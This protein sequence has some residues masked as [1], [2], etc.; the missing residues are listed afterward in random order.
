MKTVKLN[1]KE[2]KTDQIRIKENKA[3]KKTNDTKQVL[4]KG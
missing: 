2:N 3:P 1:G 4:S